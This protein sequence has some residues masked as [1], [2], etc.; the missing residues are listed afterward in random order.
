MHPSSS[1]PDLLCVVNLPLLDLLA[2]SLPRLADNANLRSPL[3]PRQDHVDG[4][5]AEYPLLLSYDHLQT[6]GS[7]TADASNQALLDYNC[8]ALYHAVVDSSRPTSNDI[9][10][11]CRS[12]IVCMMLFRILPGLYQRT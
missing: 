12:S 3:P 5:K 7:V 6:S 11:I 4:C 10:A 1:R 2:G 9:A 8:L